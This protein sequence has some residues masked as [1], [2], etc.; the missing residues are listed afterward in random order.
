METIS[1]SPPRTLPTES[2]TS[3]TSPPAAAYSQPTLRNQ[4]SLQVQA[5]CPPPS[6]TPAAQRSSSRI[7]LT[8]PL[9]PLATSSLT[10]SQPMVLSPLQVPTQPET[11]PSRSPLIPP[12]STSTRPTASMATSR[13][14]PSQALRS[15]ASEH[16]LPARNLLPFSLIHILDSS[17]MS[18]TSSEAMASALS[19]AL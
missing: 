3:S 8:F 6:S 13:H 19:R 7:A 15:P 14:S 10:P 17:F 1:T 5:H 18:P 11:L 2:A 9:H 12:E 16:T 4:L